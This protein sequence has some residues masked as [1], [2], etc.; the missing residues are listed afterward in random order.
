MKVY[1]GKPIT[2][3]MIFDW[4]GYV[5]SQYPGVRYEDVETEILKRL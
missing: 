4:W 5:M 3:A 1:K 2:K